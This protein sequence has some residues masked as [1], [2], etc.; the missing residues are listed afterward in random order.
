MTSGKQ[1]IDTHIY[2]IDSNCEPNNQY[3][4]IFAKIRPLTQ[5]ED[6]EEKKVLEKM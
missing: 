2:F 4:Q 5:E 1:I 3:V 6:H